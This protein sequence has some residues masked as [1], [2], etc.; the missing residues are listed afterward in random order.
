MAPGHRPHNGMHQEGLPLAVLLPA[1]QRSLLVVDSLRNNWFTH[2]GRGALRF[3]ETHRSHVGGRHCTHTG[4]SH[5][6]TRENEVTSCRTRVEMESIAL[7][8]A[9][10]LEHQASSAPWN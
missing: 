4:G 9:S 10:R 5:S 8:E 6:A 1:G 7:S 3:K 2:G